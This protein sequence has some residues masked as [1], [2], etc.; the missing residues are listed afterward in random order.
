MG[1]TIWGII[2][3]ATSRILVSPFDRWVLS[4]LYPLTYGAITLDRNFKRGD[5]DCFAGK[6]VIYNARLGVKNSL[7]LAT[8]DHQFNKD[9]SDLLGTQKSAAFVVVIESDLVDGDEIQPPVRFRRNFCYLNQLPKPELSLLILITIILGISGYTISN[10]SNT[11]PTKWIFGAITALFGSLLVKEFEDSALSAL[12][13]QREILEMQSLNQMINQF[14]LS[15]QM[16]NELKMSETEYDF[17]VEEIKRQL[18]SII[19]SSASV[20]NSEVAQNFMSHLAE[21]I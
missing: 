18:R 2:F 14:R 19:S 1:G 15:R 8:R 3:R 16:K 6:L 11:D 17:N 21:N 12:R 7:G 13:A 20:E 5:E 9:I 4:A 10:W